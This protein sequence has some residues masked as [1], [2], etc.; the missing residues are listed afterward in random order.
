MASVVP[1]LD[2][3]REKIVDDYDLNRYLNV[4]HETDRYMASDHLRLRAC[5][6]E[7]RRPEE[8]PDGPSSKRP[9]G[10]TRADA[11]GRRYESAFGPSF[12]S[13]FAP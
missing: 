6:I 1:L 7:L 9:S 13:R 5:C 12:R 2:L 11:D 3:L 8:Q 10:P 4:H